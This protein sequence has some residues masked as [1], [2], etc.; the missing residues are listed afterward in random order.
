MTNII[1]FPRKK[2]RDIGL[3]SFLDHQNDS[4]ELLIRDIINMSDYEISDELSSMD[5][6]EIQKFS[7]FLDKE[8]LRIRDQ[9]S[10]LTV[11]VTLLKRVSSMTHALYKI[12][13]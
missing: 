11:D 13:N 1:K 3:N 2:V 8:I 9:I 6:Q 10:L 5:K 4:C 7:F 12:A